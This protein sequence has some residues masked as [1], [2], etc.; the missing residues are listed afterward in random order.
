MNVLVVTV[1][2]LDKPLY[3]VRLSTLCLQQRRHQQAA[4]VQHTT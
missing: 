4:C 2:H 1:L 3:S